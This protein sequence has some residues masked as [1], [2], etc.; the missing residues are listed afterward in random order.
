M[1]D[2]KCT[3]E[4]SCVAIKPALLLGT[5]FLGGEKK[6]KQEEEKKNK[7]DFKNCPLPY[8]VQALSSFIGILCV[9]SWLD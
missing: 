6:K 8:K 3:V 5:L 9:N 7:L 4:M 1:R 2:I